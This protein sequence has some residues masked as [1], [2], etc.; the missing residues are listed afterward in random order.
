MTNS[1]KQERY[2]RKEALKKMAGEA[3]MRIQMSGWEFSGRMEQIPESLKRLENAINLPN[4]WTDEDYAAAVKVVQ[5]IM[6]DTYDNPHLLNNDI[7]DHH[8]DG[9]FNPNNSN[10]MKSMTELRKAETDSRKLI[11]TILSAI[12]LSG[13]ST[14]D[15]IATILETLRILGRRLMDS[16]NIPRSHATAFAMTAIGQQ[17]QKPDWFIKELTPTLGNQLGDEKTQE[18]AQSLSN[19]KIGDF[20]YE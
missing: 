18:L 20:D 10:P 15:S 19:F 8:R 9:I 1:E 5:N 4:N 16:N 14:P 12:E 13:L 11:H 2:R 7:N 17:F 3:S 6:L